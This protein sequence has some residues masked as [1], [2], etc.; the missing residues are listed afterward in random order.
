[1]KKLRI[2]NDELKTKLLENEKLKVKWFI[3]VKVTELEDLRKRLEES[4]KY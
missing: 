3:Y 4:S 1:M 2:G